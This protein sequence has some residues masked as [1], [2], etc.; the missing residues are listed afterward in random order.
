MHRNPAPMFTIA[1]T[2]HRELQDEVARLQLAREAWRDDPTMHPAISTACRQLGAALV[3]AVQELKLI[4]RGTVSLTS[5][6]A[7]PR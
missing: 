1:D 3:R 4:S 5:R 6:G 7:V 2:L